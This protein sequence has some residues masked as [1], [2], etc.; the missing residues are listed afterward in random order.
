M[1][2]ILASKRLPNDSEIPVIVKSAPSKEV[3]EYGNQIRAKGKKHKIK[4]PLGLIEKIQ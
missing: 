4:R 3:Q 2:K 1:L